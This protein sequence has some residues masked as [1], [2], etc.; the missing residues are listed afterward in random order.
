MVEEVRT[1]LE[2]VFAFWRLRVALSLPPFNHDDGSSA[3][4]PAG[5]MRIS[6]ACALKGT[7]DAVAS[8][9]DSKHARG[10]LWPESFPFP[11]ETGRV[12]NV[13]SY[14]G[15]SAASRAKTICA[16]LIAS[17]SLKRWIQVAASTG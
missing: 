17:C 10:F 12:V 5:L 8:Q 15:A 16:T 14:F 11:P 7:M 9:T 6:L 13:R 2:T 3:A 4:H 1:A